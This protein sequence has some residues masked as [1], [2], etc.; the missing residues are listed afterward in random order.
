M[1]ATA[2]IMRTEDISESKET[3][4]ARATERQENII[5]GLMQQFEGAGGPGSA[6]VYR[7]EADIRLAQAVIANLGPRLSGDFEVVVA[8]DG[9]YGVIKT[10]SQQDARR[11]DAKVSQL[12]GLLHTTPPG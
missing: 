1:K 11:I 7:E 6:L 10:G 2:V 8:R 12:R 3:A 5:A 4:Q 9:G